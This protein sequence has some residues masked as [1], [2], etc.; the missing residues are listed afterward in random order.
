MKGS[1]GR[2]H[3][4]DREDGGQYVRAERFSAGHHGGRDKRTVHGSC[5]DGAIGRLIW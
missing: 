1:A 5:C 4:I 2:Q 3:F